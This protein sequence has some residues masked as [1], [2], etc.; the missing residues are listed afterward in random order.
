M[1]ISQRSI[2]VSFF[3][4]IAAIVLPGC[5]SMRVLSS[6]PP[7]KAIVVEKPLEFTFGLGTKLTM[8]VGDYKPVMEDNNGY[9]YQ[10]P[11]K[12]VARDIFSY[13][14]DGGLYVKRGETNPC[15]WYAIDERNFT[16]TGNL[17]HN[18][19]AKLIE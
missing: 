15:R 8:P 7:V 3:A 17:P 4:T 9:Y 14:A 16:K 6:A 12:L 10:A 1:R 13:V 2:L 19:Q 5:A 18:F 11:S